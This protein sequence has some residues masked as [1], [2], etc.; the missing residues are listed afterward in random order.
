VLLTAFLAF[1][2][3]GFGIWLI[4][5]LFRIN[6]GSQVFIGVAAI[7][8]IIVMITGGTVALTDVQVTTG[9]VIEKNYDEHNFSVSNQDDAF[10]NNRTV[11]ER[12]TKRVSITDQFGSAFGQL[13][14]GG[15]ELIVGALLLMADLEELSFS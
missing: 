8:A 7:G 12:T 9:E 5:H 1:S 6:G 14:L 11:V 10:V 3:F 2:A 4:G 13:G 15:L